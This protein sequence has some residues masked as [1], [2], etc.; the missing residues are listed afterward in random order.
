MLETA[1]TIKRVLAKYNRPLKPLDSSQLGLD[2]AIP[3][4]DR[5]E[6]LLGQPWDKKEDKVGPSWTLNLGKKV[7]GKHKTEDLTLDNVHQQ[8]WTRRTLLRLLMSLFDPLGIFCN[9]FIMNFKTLFSKVCK[10][11][12]QSDYDLEI[13]SRDIELRNAIVENTKKNNNA[14]HQ[15]YAL[16]SNPPA[17]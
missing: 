11:F 5:L 4:E 12:P 8:V 16:E 13:G 6:T 9:H 10:K 14:R 7:K 17:K 15:P 3:K 2:H 1:D